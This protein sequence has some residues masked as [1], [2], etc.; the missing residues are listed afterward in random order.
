MREAGEKHV[1]RVDGVRLACRRLRAVRTHDRMSG[2]E[3]DE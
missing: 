3:I 2:H 1:R